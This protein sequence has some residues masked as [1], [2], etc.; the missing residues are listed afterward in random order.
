MTTSSQCYR[1]CTSFQFDV[2]WIS[3]WPPS[4]TC[5]C[6]AWLQSIWPPTVSWSP[7]KAS[8]A[9]FCCMLSEGPTA[10]LWRQVFC[11]CN[12]NGKRHFYFGDEIVAQCELWLT[13]KVAPHTLFEL[14]HCHAFLSL[15]LVLTH[16][17]LEHDVT[18]DRRYQHSFMYHTANVRICLVVWSKRHLQLKPLSLLTKH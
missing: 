6:P 1:S 12:L 2:G 4:S 13:A 14:W 8:L 5:H 15:V 16:M 11:S 3:R 7:T 18:T 9:A 10:K 17:T